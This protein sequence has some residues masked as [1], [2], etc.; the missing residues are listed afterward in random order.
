VSGR[1]ARRKARHQEE[2]RPHR[3][4]SGHRH[5]LP[6]PA[7]E[8][9][10]TLVDRRSKADARERLACGGASR[11][12]RV[13]ADREA[14]GDILA[15]REPGE[16]R[17]LLEDQAAVGGRALDRIAEETDLARG[18]RLEP[19]DQVEQ[20]RLAAAR[21]AEQHHELARG[22]VEV[23]SRERLMRALRPGRPDLAHATAGDG[24][25]R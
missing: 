16:E 18:R 7:R 25:G 17:R 11:L 19:G 14:E 22:D 4:R 24:I 21:G 15:D 2:L 9:V 1:R 20:R 3:E 12:R 6:H 8:L 13:A 10:G 5:T 23:D